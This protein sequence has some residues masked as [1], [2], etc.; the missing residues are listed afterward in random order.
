[1]K[2]NP[3]DSQG[4]W[5]YYALGPSWEINRVYQF[6]LFPWSKLA[7]IRA[8]QESSLPMRRTSLENSKCQNKLKDLADYGPKTSMASARTEKK[9]LQLFVCKGKKLLAALMLS[10]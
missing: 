7:S 9:K 6:R 3:G 8:K 4:L 5:L 10:E 1:M 2:W